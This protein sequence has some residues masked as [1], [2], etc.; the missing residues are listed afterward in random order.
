MTLLT[1]W[2]LR[3][4]AGAG[5]I[6]FDMSYEQVVARIGAPSQP[7]STLWGSDSQRAG[8]A[9]GTLAIHFA[10]TLARIEYIEFSGGGSLRPLLTGWCPFERQADEVVAALTASGWSFD[11]DDPEV[12]YS[13]IFKAQQLSLWRPAMPEG[14]GDDVGLF[15]AAVGVGRSGYYG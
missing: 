1:E 14:P 9:E 7:L 3:P 15:F 10:H 12:G 2:E 6:Q 4:L 11:A 8:W 13:Y 5:P